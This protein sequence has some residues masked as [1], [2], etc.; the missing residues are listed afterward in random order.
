MSKKKK[1]KKKHQIEKKKKSNAS[2]VILAVCVSA[3]FVL[4][5]VGVIVFDRVTNIKYA[6]FVGHT[7]Q[8]K[9]AYDKSGKKVDLYNIYNVQY[10]SYHG[11]LQFNED[12]T[13]SLWMTPGPDDGTNEGT[14]TYNTWDN[15]INGKYNSGK[16]IDFKIVRNEDGSLNRIEAPYEEYTIYF[17]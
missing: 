3:A 9:A 15:V 6:D 14:F 2:S 10:D 5:I 8:S 1:P 17:S 11:T 16:K 7:M 4:I 12:K 13:F